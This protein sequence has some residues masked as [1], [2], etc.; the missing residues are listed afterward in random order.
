[1][2][3]E[4]ENKKNPEVVFCDEVK[5]VRVICYKYCYKKEDHLGIIVERAEGKDTVNHHIVWKRTGFGE[6]V[7]EYVRF[8][9]VSGTGLVRDIVDGK[10]RIHYIDNILDKILNYIKKYKEESNDNG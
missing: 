5:G 7:N 9:L 4:Y 2:F 1:M 3:E 10:E 6:L 8:P